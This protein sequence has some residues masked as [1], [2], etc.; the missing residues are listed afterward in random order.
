MTVLRTA[1]WFV[2]F[3]GALVYLYPQMKQAQRLPATGEADAAR[4]IVQQG[5]PRWAKCI[6]RLAGV[7]VSV[8]GRENIPAD[9]AV[10][11][12]P[13]HQGNYDIPL[14]LT[15]LDAPHALIAKIE[16]K[17][18]PLVRTW[19]TLLGCV[20]LD[21]KNPRQAVTA[22]ADAGKVLQAGHS[23]I[24]FPEGTRSKGG[25][26]GEFKSGAFKMACKAKAPIVPIVI[27]GS[28]KIMEANGNLM[29]PAHVNITIL[30]PV[31]TA[32]LTRE[33]QK[34]LP[35]QIAQSIAIYLEQKEG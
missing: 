4:A 34:A 21:R 1:Y 17:K 7:T 32:A 3:F 8:T 20:F 9:T 19:M 26:M 16:L 31:A 6:S 24:V 10:V 13:N 30:P 22:L 33:E 5:V 28:Y 18:I 11:F 27:D 15:Q 25:P 2:F 23:M 12:T 35:Q 29:R 14:M